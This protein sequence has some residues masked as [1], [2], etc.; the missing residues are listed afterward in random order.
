MRMMYY[1]QLGGSHSKLQGNDLEIISIA[2]E[3]AGVIYDFHTQWNI[4]LSYGSG[5]KW[6]EASVFR[7]G[8]WLGCRDWATSGK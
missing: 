2:T 7:M 8:V 5:I 3:N 1:Y 6:V 4:A